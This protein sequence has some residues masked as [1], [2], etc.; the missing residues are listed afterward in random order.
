MWGA[1][2]LSH[3]FS[4]IAENPQRADQ[5]TLCGWLEYVVKLYPILSLLSMQVIKP[6]RKTLRFSDRDRRP[7]PFK[8]AWEVG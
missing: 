7:V 6:S 4:W 1:M 2:M 5:S 8:V 3:F